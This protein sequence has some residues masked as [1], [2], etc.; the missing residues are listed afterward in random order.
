MAT[1]QNT[2]KCGV[3]YCQS[4]IKVEIG[5]TFTITRAVPPV[6]PSTLQLAKVEPFDAFWCPWL[7]AAFQEK[8]LS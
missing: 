8:A 6:L 3:P 7:Q 5:M 1:T 4:Q 2:N